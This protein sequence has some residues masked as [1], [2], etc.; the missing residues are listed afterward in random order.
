M[1]KSIYFIFAASLLIPCRSLVAQQTAVHATALG[2]RF[3]I[4]DFDRRPFQKISPLNK[5]VGLNFVKGIN[6][7]LDWT[8]EADIYFVDSASLIKEKSKSLLFQACI[9]AR[10]RIADPKGKVQPFL[11]AG[12]G[13]STYKN[14]LVSAYPL[15]LGIEFCFM[16]EAYITLESRYRFTAPAVINR[17]LFYSIG[18]SGTINNRN[19]KQKKETINRIPTT[20][21][22][23]N[24]LDTDQDGIVDSLDARPTEPGMAA[25]NGCPDTDRDGIMNKADSCPLVPGFAR[26]NG[27]PIPDVDGDGVDDEKD[28][29]RTIPGLVRYQGCPV[30]DLDGDGINDEKDSCKSISGNGPHGCPFTSDE[31]E[32]IL[33]RAATRIF[34]AS[35]K[36]E[37]FAESYSSLDSVALIMNKNPHINILIE[38]HTDNTSTPALNLELSINRCMAVKKYLISQGVDDKRLSVKGWGQQKP[39][40]SNATTEGKA[41]NR[42]VEL[43]LLK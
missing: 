41:K 6:R 14:H 28:S 38:G 25:F 33:Q 40:D 39:I 2:T 37:L 17:H 8:L 21:S 36:F 15:G 32:R 13:F 30:P 22:A 11:L 10:A 27:C 35:G 29:C 3:S 4:I 43:H 19:K 23:V 5:G 9:A 24:V 26:Y 42:R 34:F 18:I 1:T 12:I 20:L 7:R 31:A 16:P